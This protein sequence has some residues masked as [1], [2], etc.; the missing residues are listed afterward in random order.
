MSFNITPYKSRPAPGQQ[1]STPFRSSSASKFRSSLVPSSRP[2]PARS[3]N[4]SSK[5]P[6]P[7]SS[8]RD[9][10]GTS[11]PRSQRTTV[12][13]PDLPA[14]ATRPPPSVRK[15]APRKSVSTGMSNTGSTEPFKM[16]IPSPDPGLTGQALA[17]EVPD[18]PNRTN[19]VYA[20][21][22]LAH[23]CP[24]HFDELQRRQFFCI[25]DL[26]RLKYAADEIFT[27]KDWKL[28]ILNFAKEYEKSR[29]LIMLRYG[30][31][32]F[33]NIK[34]SNEVVRKWRAAHGL[35]PESEDDQGS[36][37]RNNR[38]PAPA[39]STKRKAEEEPTPTNNTSLSAPVNQNK[40]R[41]LTQEVDATPAGPASFKKNKRKAEATE[42]LDED[43]PAKQ[44]KA[45][46]SPATSLFESIINKPRPGDVS[47]SKSSS[48]TT[49]LFGVSKPKDS[50]D[51]N[52]A[53]K[54]NPFQQNRSDSLPTP[55]KTNTT[56][57]SKSVL[58]GDEVGSTPVTTT[59]NI[60]SYLSESASSSSGNE[61]DDDHDTDEEPEKDSDEQD[62]SAAIST[63]T[64]TPPA[65]NGSSIF[66]T[67]KAATTNIFGGLPSS[68][69]QT[70][71]GG[72]FGRVKVGADDQPVRAHP[73]PEELKS[74]SAIQ[75][76]AANEQPTKT[77]AK[78]PGDYTFN[79]ATTP[80][81]FGQPTVDVSKSSGTAD[82]GPGVK[83]D[84]SDSKK[85]VSMFGPSDQANSFLKPTVS[86]LFESSGSAKPKASEAPASIFASQKPSP[87]A[88][89]IFGAASTA[90]KAKVSFGGNDQVNGTSSTIDK[91]AVSL[92]GQPTNAF[93]TTQTTSPQNIINDKPAS[94]T[95][96]KSQSPNIFDKSFTAQTEDQAKNVPDNAKASL[97]LSNG[98]SNPIFGSAKDTNAG[99]NIPTAEKTQTPSI[100]N[101]SFTSGNGTQVKTPD[102]PKPTTD[103]F[104]RGSTSFFGAPKANGTAPAGT[105]SLFGQTGKPVVPNPP[106]SDKPT[107]DD[108]NKE[109]TGSV[110][111]PKASMTPSSAMSIFGTQGVSSLPAPSSTLF[112]DK[113]PAEP[114]K[115]ASSVFSS[116]P[117]AH[118]SIFGS[119]TQPDQTTNTQPSSI[120]VGA[121]ATASSGNSFGASNTQANGSDFKNTAFQF[122]SAA[123]IGGSNG[124]PFGQNSSSGSF[125]FTAGGGNK[126]INNPFSAPQAGSQSSAPAVGGGSFTAPP[127]SS[128]NSSFG[129]QQFSAPKA[130]PVPQGGT[131]FGGSGNTNGAPSFNFMQAS[132]SQNSSDSKFPKASVVNTFGHLQANEGSSFANSPYPAPSSM[133]TT[134]VN[135][136]PEPQSPHEEGEGGSQEQIKLTDGGPGEE[137]EIIV[138]EVRAKAIK[139]IPVVKG[140][141]DQPKSPWST[142]GV[143]PLRVL[144]NKSTGAVRVLLRAEPRGHIALN[145]TILAD[146]E[147]KPKEK[148]VNFV[149]ASDDGSGLET[150]VLQ[151]KKP[152]FATELS[153][154]LEA[155]KGANKK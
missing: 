138:H 37:H 31:Y 129:Q 79:P 55:A 127:F 77:P 96:T 52:F 81:S 73:S 3:S 117:P 153:G 143:G 25:L 130:A 71:K 145:K 26:R 154:V 58:S 103:L 142:Q 40:R 139:Y 13:A 39:R 43:K 18:D 86:G 59:R 111:G 36:S 19:S 65:Q 94:A 17:K 133:G 125:T 116:A 68:I 27:K 113:K 69:D 50:Q 51:T 109:N 76:P 62:P 137:D 30:L 32:E 61:N 8:A 151:M 53:I 45:G 148:T 15:F 97:D 24:P 118:G 49:T 144:K 83:S 14:E 91:P 35:P 85:P 72:L 23:K 131:L 134:P 63:S 74:T 21:Q 75:P 146:V 66:S 87:T 110:L 67:G 135:G 42:D 122:G 80:I 48:L 57:T 89:S 150:W 136:T 132:P 115:S 4:P 123:P 28:N 7:S 98:N 29:G 78:P 88:T 140:E 1:G 16:R 128:F 106:S 121:G 141:E 114:A 2:S 46:P 44:Q 107:P 82:V 84:A 101:K 102:D 152:E 54:A 11:T 104:N 112:G 20:D 5:S 120:S 92:F 33:K 99:S 41:N 108:S 60:F 22:Y 95:V 93:T 147:Y 6:K 34:P 105:K 70:S 124:F 9:L 126:P 12:F 149:A 56:A 90:P 38:T 10:F 47:P 119:G 64:S 100:F 155:N